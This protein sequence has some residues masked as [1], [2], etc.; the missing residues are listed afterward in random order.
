MNDF[1]ARV[2]KT[3]LSIT[4][5]FNT[6]TLAPL[7]R[8]VPGTDDRGAHNTVLLVH[9]FHDSAVSMEPMRRWLIARGWKASA[10]SL[11]PSDG[12][13]TLE[14]LAKQLANYV[15]ES[16]PA[17][18]KIDLVG[19]SMGGLV[20]RY[21]VQRLNG[22]SRVDKLITVS[23]PNHGTWLAAMS[24]KPGCLEMRPSSTFLASLNRDTDSLADVLYTSI[25]T[26][27]DLM[28]VPAWSSR[29]PVGH[30]QRFWAPAHPL[31]ILQVGCFRKIENCLSVT[32]ASGSESKTRN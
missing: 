19:F 3:A 15:S 13:A 21:Y 2:W 23:S 6:T 26:P 4:A 18:Q 7:Y 29:M 5:F 9:G 32:R 17:D 31:M 25:W 14:D 30:E 24:K 16:F 10:V 11:S 27:L 1:T 28:I 12:T 20:C 22:A 8:Y